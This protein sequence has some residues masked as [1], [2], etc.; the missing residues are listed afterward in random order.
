MTEPVQHHI[1][2]NVSYTSGAKGEKV[3]ID[4]QRALVGSGAHCDVCLPPGLAATEHV[5]LLLDAEGVLAH[6][7]ATEPLATIG[8][9]PFR[10]QRLEPGA[11][12]AIGE[13]VLTVELERVASAAIKRKGGLGPMGT[14]CLAIIVPVVGYMAFDDSDE[15]EST[16]IPPQPTLFASSAPRCPARDPDSARA[17]AMEHHVQAE[18]RRE[19]RR[20]AAREGVDA[21]GLYQEAA[22]CFRAGGDP[23]SADEARA[24]GVALKSK[25][26]E[27]YRGHQIRLEHALSVEEV[28]TAVREVKILRAYTQPLTG[29]YVNWL[30]GTERSLL[31]R[32]NKPK[33][34]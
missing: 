15:D 21:V 9:N 24:V 18:A 1:V 25:V 11:S 5:E 31:M 7:Q 22:E 19:R 23:A 10:R 34:D 2:V 13:V 28:D 33:S 20:F 26:E 14:L 4:S 8:G 30:Q 16:A 29:R 3:V 27:D 17:A 6:C 32:K 12:I